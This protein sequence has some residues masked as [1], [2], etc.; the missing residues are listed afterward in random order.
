MATTRTYPPGVPCWIDTEQPDPD[1]ARHFYGTLLDWTFE[2]VA[3][4][5]ADSGGYHVASLA[6]RPVA[7]IAP[8]SANPGAVAWNTYVAVADADATAQTVAEAGGTVEGEPADAGPAGRLARCV[9]PAG[10]SFRLWQPSA[11][12]GAQAVNVPGTWNFSDLHTPD[13]DDALRFYS[14]VFGWEAKAIDAGAAE[15]ATLLRVPG[16]GAHLRE[17]VDP[18]IDER[19]VGAP[20]GFADGVGWVAK[21]EPEHDRPHWH[22]TISVV[23]RSE[24]AKTAQRLGAEIVSERD[25]RWSRTAIVVDP[26]GATFTISQF[27]AG[28]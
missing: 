17:T 4:C 5:E 15:W 26:Q 8:A 1:A 19:Q 27:R 12:A 9:D 3:A 21:L 24:T 10:A 7:A 22:V 23:D 13:P 25:A 20:E 6:G 16:Y 2:D 18:G 11:R 14:E 28:E